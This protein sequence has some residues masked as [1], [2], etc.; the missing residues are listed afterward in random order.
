M[1]INLKILVL[2]TV[3][4]TTYSSCE[5]EPLFSG[6][7][8]NATVNDWTWANFWNEY[9]FDKLDDPRLTK[10][11]ITS[12]N[13]FKN[14]Q[15]YHNCINDDLYSLV[16]MTTSPSKYDNASLNV[17]FSLGEGE[18]TKQIYYPI[19]LSNPS[20]DCKSISDVNLSFKD[21]D[22]FYELYKLDTTYN[23]LI[24]VTRQNNKEIE[25]HFDLMFTWN[26]E[27]TPFNGETK[28]FK[29]KLHIVCNKFVA[30]YIDDYYK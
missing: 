5:K 16:I 15:K 27:K 12:V 26:E 17:T 18:K 19:K 13:Y 2:F 28:F 14:P 4:M 1:K 8:I 3:V 6:G 10:N 21:W 23:N 7:E 20:E 30:K 24:A 25:G 9:W 29:E 11:E 22:V